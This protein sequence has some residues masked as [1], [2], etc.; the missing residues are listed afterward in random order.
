MEKQSQVIKDIYVDFAGKQELRVILSSVQIWYNWKY[1][2]INE[3]W[4][5]NKKHSKNIKNTTHN[6][7]EKSCVN[8]QKYSTANYQ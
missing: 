8:C 4:F 3:R 1:H 2:S 7:A 5:R 6:F